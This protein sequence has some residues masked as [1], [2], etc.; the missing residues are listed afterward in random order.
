VITTPVVEEGAMRQRVGSVM[1]VVL[2]VAMV[3]GCSRGSDNRV[4]EGDRNS[5]SASPTYQ[6]GSR[7]DMGPN[8]PSG[9]VVSGVPSSNNPPPA[10]APKTNAK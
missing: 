2:A 6:P 1:V 3:A 4:G 8:A 10:D 5:G 7:V 9:G